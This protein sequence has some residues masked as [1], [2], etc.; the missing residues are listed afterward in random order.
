MKNIRSVDTAVRIYYENIVLGNKEI[1][2]LLDVTGSATV[3]RLK[4]QAV[5]VMDKKGV[6]RW[7][8]TVETKCAY[9]AWGLDINELERRRNKLLKLGMLKTGQAT[10]NDAV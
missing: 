10:C 2:E 1:R 9:E 5:K 8:T 7:G 4:N 3:T 6:M